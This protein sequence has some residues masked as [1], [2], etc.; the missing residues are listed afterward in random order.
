MQVREAPESDVEAI[1][2]VHAA[3]IRELGRRTYSD[4]QVE[5]WAAGCETADYAD[6]VE[7]DCYFVVAETEDGDSAD[8]VA[9]GSLWFT[10]P[11]DYERPLDAEVTAVYVHPSAARTGVGSAV[12][13]DLEDRARNRGATTLGLTASTNAVPFYQARGYETVR[14]R[15]HEFSGHESTGVEGTVVEMY[16]EL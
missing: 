11:D 13:A 8:V 9:F 7:D 16:K 3:S 12:L 4:E 15:S 2:R 10:P 6:I 5:A 14:E 1:R